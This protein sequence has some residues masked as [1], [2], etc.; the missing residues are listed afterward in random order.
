VGE[1]HCS[2]GVSIGLSLYPLDGGDAKGLIRVADAA[3]YA[4][5]QQ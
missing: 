4:D 1:G 3:M 5:K 2:V